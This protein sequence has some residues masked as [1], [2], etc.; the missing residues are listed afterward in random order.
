MSWDLGW[1]RR[2]FASPR[3]HCWHRTSAEKEQ[4][5]DLAGL[6]LWD[7]LVGAN[8]NMPAQQPTRYGVADPVP[9]GLLGQMVW[10][11]WGNLVARSSNS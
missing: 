4:N 11:F 2:V 10:P 8:Y 6:L 5:K 7:I 3:F 1:L 9:D